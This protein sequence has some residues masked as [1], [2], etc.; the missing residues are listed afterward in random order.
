LKRAIGMK[1]LQEHISVPRN[2]LLGNSRERSEQSERMLMPARFVPALALSAE[3]GE[4][5]LWFAFRGNELLVILA[6]E[7]V[8][9]PEA[10]KLSELE[11]PLRQR[12]YLGQLDGQACFAVEL[13]DRTAAPKGMSF[14]GLRGLFG[15]LDDQ[16]FSLAGRAAQIVNWDQTHRFCGRCGTPTATKKDERAKLCPKCGLLSFPLLSPAIIV[17]VVHGPKI[18]L[19]RANHFP[20]GFYSVLAGFVEPGETLEECVHREVQEEVGLQ[21]KN[22]RYFGSQPWP[23]PHSLMI[24][25]TAEFAGGR[26]TID[27]AEIAD[28]A[29]FSPADLPRIPGEISIA[30]RLIDWFVE[31]RQVQS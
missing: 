19:A 12:H 31:D 14:G 27:G 29:W 4:S 8:R 24:G 25:F 22:I 21:V 17:A 15:R 7:T 28:A 11:V 23:F 18:L 13:T 9:I 3:E 26:I 20:D 2:E 6:D 10:S 16:L 1:Q 5:A 30:R